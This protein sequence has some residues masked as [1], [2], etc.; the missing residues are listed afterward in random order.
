MVITTSKASVP[1]TGILLSKQDIFQGTLWENITM[2]N[3]D[4]RLIDITDMIE[5]CGLTDFLESLPQG[6]D[7]QLDPTGKRLTNEIRQGF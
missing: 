7:T 3:K 2:G 4:I 6:L 5:K 1:Q